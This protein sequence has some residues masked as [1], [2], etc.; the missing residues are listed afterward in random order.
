M[1]YT[2]TLC[3]FA[4]ETGYDSV[5][6]EAVEIAKERILDT[7]G[8]ALAGSQ[9]PAGAGRIVIEM[10]RRM[11]GNPTCTVI[12]GGFK[13]C[14]INAALANGTS[15]HTLDYDDIT[16]PLNHYSAALVPAVL[17]FAEETKASGKEAIEAYA[18]GFEVGTRIGRG[19]PD[20]YF[21]FQ[22]G[23]HH[24]SSWPSMGITIACGKLLNLTVNQM[25][26]AMGINCSAIGGTRRAFGTNTKP[27]HAGNAAR[28]GIIAA[29]LAKEGFTA[30][31][32]ILD[33]DPSV[34]PSAAMFFSYPIILSGEGNY[35]LDAM[36]E[37]LGGPL[38]LVA[39]PQGTK[40]RPGMVGAHIFA[41]IVL[42]LMQKHGFKAEQVERVECGVPATVMDIAAFH[43]PQSGDEARYSIEYQ[44]AAALL[45]GI[46]GIEQ[47]REERVHRADIREMI[48]KVHL[49]ERVE[50][51]R[52][53]Y[54]PELAQAK[55]TVKLK[56]GQEYKGEGKPPK[57][58]PGLPLAKEDLLGKYRDCAQRALPDAQVEKSIELIENFEELADVGE[59]MSL[60]MGKA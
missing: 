32:D 17:T 31:K 21:Y 2:E 7:V 26:T 30:H 14:G 37:G 6:K 59:L 16:T 53:G 24:I 44:V 60:L 12:G 56:D 48:K 4:V 28:N 55:M 42:D 23:I 27:L 46:V 11:G 22:R 57:G 35:D 50:V 47:H 43:D 1:G 51:P 5:P 40:F 10:V 33:R 54:V 49:Y 38:Q 52:E 19:M 39:S 34:R 13:T 9:E 36:V 18:M 8:V 20:K 29:T 25:R 3:R 41:H 45:D 58:A 15:A